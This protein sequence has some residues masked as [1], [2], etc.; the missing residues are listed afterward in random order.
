M[1]WPS[2]PLIR[3]LT[4]FMPQCLAVLSDKSALSLIFPWLLLLQLLVPEVTSGRG[5]VWPQCS[6][7][8][9][10]LL[11]PSRAV[12]VLSVSAEVVSCLALPRGHGPPGEGLSPQ[13]SCSACEGWPGRCL[14]SS[15][16][17][18]QEQ[19]VCGAEAGGGLLPVA[20]LLRASFLW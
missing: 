8:S 18:A 19:D 13:A 15:Q 14:W 3:P 17:R 2:W 9:L 11:V 10:P 6:S 16:P 7:P 20:L 4:F 12:P 1:L 5:L